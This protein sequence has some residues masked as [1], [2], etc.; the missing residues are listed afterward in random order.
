LGDHLRRL[1]TERRE[2]MIEKRQAG[3]T[4][5]WMTAW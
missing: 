4:A 3:M 5:R 2:Q 1:V